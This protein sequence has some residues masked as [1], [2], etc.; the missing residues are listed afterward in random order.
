[1]RKDVLMTDSQT[2][3][4]L[5]DSGNFRKLEQL[6][7]FCL[8]RPAPQAIWRPAQSP[9]LWQTADAMYHRSSSGGGSWEYRRK[10]PEEWTL[11]YYGLTLKI[12]MTDFGHLGIFPE[13]GPNWTWIREQIQNGGSNLN[14]LNTFAYTGGS[15][16]AAAAAGANVVHLDASKGIVSWAKEN[17]DQSKLGDKPIRWIVDDVV[18]FI[19]REIRRGNRYEGIILDP[20]SFG[21]GPKGEVWKFENDL[22]ALLEACRQLLPS[23]PRFVLLGAHSPGFTQLALENLLLDMMR[24]FDGEVSSMEMVIPE[25]QT[26]RYLPSGT[27]ARW[28]GRNR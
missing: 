16:L 8:D 11:T 6:G 3:Y 19:R 10:L 20:P 21:R 5:L 9:S 14:V 13:Q 23:Q 7:P 28:A 1:M 27:M 12:N 18:K 4:R 24:G 25:D 15:S 26:N 2:G 17:A 22:P